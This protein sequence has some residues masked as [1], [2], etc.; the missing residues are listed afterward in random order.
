[1]PWVADWHVHSRHSRATS[2]DLTLSALHRAALQKGIHL[3]GTGDF[4]HPGWRAEIEEQLEPAEDGL[5]RLKPELA[6]AAQQGLPP[7]CSGQV[8]FVL[9]VEISNIYKKL[10]RTRKNHNLVFVPS[11]A[12]ADRLI[13]SLS[14]IG[15]LAAD[16]RPILGLDARDLLEIALTTDPQAFLVPA[17]I[18]TPWFSLLGSKSGFD[19]VA[20]CF[21]D[22]AP[23]V[24]AAETGLSS[25]P[26]MNWRVSELDRLTL[27]SNS[28]AHSPDKLGRE[29]N[30]LEIELGFAPLRD[31][32]RTGE[33]FLGTIEFFPEEGKYHLDGHR[34]C[35]VRLMPEETL[36]AHGCCPVCGEPLT[37]GVLSRVVALADRPPGHR[38]ALAR[39]YTRLV[40]LAEVV[41]EAL[42]VGAASQR[43][44]VL[45]DKLLASLGPELTVL[46]EAPLEGIARAAGPVLGEAIR[47]VRAGEVLIEP[48]YDGE[49]GTVRLF[50]PAE[51]RHLTGQM[52][53]LGGVPQC[54]IRRAVADARRLPDA[55]VETVRTVPDAGGD[56]A[57]A[58][59]HAGV[60][61]ADAVANE[62]EPA[63]ADL[64]AGPLAGLDADQ[65]LAATRAEGPL[66]IV[67]GP[68]T[69]KTR[70][71]VARVAHQIQSGGVRP[72]QVL[73]ITF[74]RQ[75]AAELEQRLAAKLGPGR[76]PLVTTFHGLGRWLLAT[77]GGQEPAILDEEVRLELVRE[78]GRCHD[79]TAK[80]LGERLSLAKQSVDP[81][82]VL[83]DCPEDVEAYERY[84]ALLSARGA[85]D[86]D[87]L[88]H[89]SAGWLDRD[90][91]ARLEISRRFACVVVDEFQDVS[92][93]QARLVELIAPGGRALC[94]I[95]DP[96]QAIYGFRGAEPGHFAR[97]AATFVGTHRAELH[98]SYRLTR[99]LLAVALTVLG[100]SRPLSAMVD[101]PPVQVVAC[102]TPASEAEQIVVRLERL[103][104]GTSHFA[105]D[106]GRVSAGEAAPLGFGDIAILTR[107]KSQQREVQVALARS[108]IPFRL[109]AEDEPH[110]PRA[111]QVAV[112]TLHAAKGREFSVVFVAG[113]EAGLVPL[114]LPG[115]RVD[116]AEERRLLYVALTRAR[117]WCVVSY[118]ERR[119]LFGMSL[120]GGP[121]PFLRGLP[122]GSVEGS[123][124]ELPRRRAPKRQLGLF[125]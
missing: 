17:H 74:T 50:A 5:F 51:R 72:E 88:V 45:V 43:V 99:P 64:A 12:S 109:V 21:G 108:A 61:A 71:L 40:P 29:A 114:E 118:A 7:A 120:P 124:A 117:R 35:Q 70:T 4:T 15:N 97:F 34:K 11:L 62:T 105:I 1:M 47:R 68:G 102:S 69:G 6:R 25:D 73:A 19:A 125:E 44:R 13:E 10:G 112:M 42:G 18:W 33:G 75:A 82:R 55:P 110:D 92:D 32:L 48:G 81:R 87:D 101:G 104:G 94:A 122:G 80:R 84:Q 38:P 90:P 98:T 85:V 24:F 53:L 106:S 49:Y 103:L 56:M 96:D 23:Q 30:R 67:A 111:Q 37:V 39:D 65:R 121:S 83:G 60:D 16:G 59:A 66:L 63:C 8:R 107:T 46:T 78:A 27:I 95:G 36:N 76:G 113:V 22:L 86:L 89:A 116:P 79:R 54:P 119:T 123:R 14:R 41:G 20:E 91:N 26:S 93:V 100:H 3:V 28:D 77:L 52:V 2:P 9:T 58:M 31:A 57:N 115:F